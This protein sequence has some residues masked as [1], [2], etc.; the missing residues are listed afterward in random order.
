MVS[1]QRQ[2]TEQEGNVIESMP[3]LIDNNDSSRLENLEPTLQHDSKLSTLLN[4]G[5]FEFDS[6]AFDNV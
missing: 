3:S 5:A 4:S 6:N 2:V 1:A